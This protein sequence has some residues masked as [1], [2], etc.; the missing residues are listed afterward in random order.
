MYRWGSGDE[1]KGQALVVVAVLRSDGR[2]DEVRKEIGALVRERIGAIAVPRGITF[3][4]MLPKTRSGKIMRRVIKAVAEGHEIG[5]LST[6]EDDASVDE[7]RAA[8]TTLQSGC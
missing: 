3:V 2:S 8:V 1:V 7:V 6:I 4:E 5:D